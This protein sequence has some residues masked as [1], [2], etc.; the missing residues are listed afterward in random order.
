[1]LIRTLLAL[2]SSLIA[3][4]CATTVNTEFDRSV[5]FAQYNTFYWLTPEAQ[6]VRDPILDSQILD[7]RVQTSVI[8]A[9]IDNGFQESA[10]NPDFFVTYH[11]ASSTRLRA[12]AFGGGVGYS[13]FHPSW[14]HAMII[15][16][17][18]VRSYELGMLLIDIVD[19]RTDTLIWRGWS[20]DLLTPQNFSDEAVNAIVRKIL[21]KFPPIA[22]AA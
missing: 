17:P 10:K 7:R 3:V 18:V 19:R 11:A 12:S 13:H 5:D 9:L 6:P 8:T 22:P 20:A 16:A 4:G 2:F 15:D 14:S 21:A 1:M